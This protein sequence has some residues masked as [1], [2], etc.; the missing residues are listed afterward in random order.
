M[1][2]LIKA[3]QLILSLSILV[4]IHELGH[5]VFA[6]L[7][8]VRVDKFYLFFDIKFSLFKFKPKNSDTEYGVGWLP[9]G[10]Y[11]KISGMID[12]SMDTEQMAQEPQPWEFRS[13]PAWQRLLIMVGGALFNVLLAILI[14]SM[15]LFAWGDTYLANKDVVRGIAYDSIATEMGFQTGDKII[16]INGNSVERFEN[17]QKELLYDG[18]TVRI[19][20]NGVQQYIAI[21]HTQFAPVLV[22]QRIFQAS[23]P[24]IV[25][26][27]GEGSQNSG[28]DLRKNDTV[29]GINGQAMTDYF[30]IRHTFGQHRNEE[31]AL[32]IKRGNDTLTVAAQINSEGLI[33]INPRIELKELFHLTNVNYGLLAS[34]PAGVQKTGKRIQ[35]QL[36]DLKLMVTPKTG[37][38]KQVGSFLTIGSIYSPTWDWQRFWDITALLSIMLAVIN[39]LPIPALDGG[40]VMFLLY[41]VI[42]R[43]KPSDK[44]L[45]YAQMVGMA[46]LLIIMVYAL[47]NDV[48]RHI[49]K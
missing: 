47:G 46:I 24:F 26:K 20:R 27:I 10:G 22:K 37:T 6:R 25:E 4:L 7:F 31:I 29:I 35:D 16:A 36:S 21:D 49:I 28:I 18:G 40:H 19:E 8:K 3:A 39:L 5:F 2:I 11:C 15:T 33:G 30:L 44:F 14:Y 13:K 12:E 34:I 48:F 1:E 45:G 17:I 32:L 9:L 41:E 43:R 42:T 38:Y 23:I